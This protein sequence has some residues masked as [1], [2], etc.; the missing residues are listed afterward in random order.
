MP[1]SV[2]TGRS[3]ALLQTRDPREVERL[4]SLTRL[5]DSAIAIPGTRYRFGLD[6]LIGIVPGIGDV[7]GAI[8]SSYIIL[9]AARLGASK[10]TLIRMMGNV[11]L[12]TIVGG[13]PFLGD[14][15]DAGWKANTRNLQ[16]LEGH[17]QRPA[18]TA[19]TSRRVLLLVVLGLVLL[20]AGIVALGV[21][22]ANLITAAVR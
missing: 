5:L 11:A 7:I 13:I 19:R 1:D 21:L 14:L 17:L 22:L 16:L 9:Q 6:A 10:P 18:T 15:F 8:F 20:L 2:R 12:D 3:D 4:R